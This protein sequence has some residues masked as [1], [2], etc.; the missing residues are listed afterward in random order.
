VA[1]EWKNAE[2]RDND[3]LKAKARFLVADI[4]K[5]DSDKVPK[6]WELGETLVTI[7]ASDEEK[8]SIAKGHN[9]YYRSIQLYRYFPTLA[10]AKAFRG[11][12]EDALKASQKGIK[13]RRAPFVRLPE[14][15]KRIEALVENLWWR[16]PNCDHE[17]M[18]D[19][20]SAI[21]AKY[22]RNCRHG[23]IESDDE[24]PVGSGTV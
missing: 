14:A 20:L 18:S 24:T 1:S 19:F 3:R 9:K 10:R 6:L 16:S 15:A 13:P 23:G 2:G 21:A 8:F 4:E 11:T 17:R 5:A 7:E 22:R 12:L